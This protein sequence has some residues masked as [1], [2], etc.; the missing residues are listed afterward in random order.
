MTDCAFDR[1]VV[2]GA[3]KETSMRTVEEA[4]LFLRLRLRE[5]FT[6]AGL[7]ALLMLERAGE[8]AEV[9]EARQAF[10][11]W[12]SKEQFIFSVPQREGAYR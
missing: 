1:P 7:S 10:C 9:E 5:R 3:L 6:L 8:A 12:A 2:L 11:S 4:A